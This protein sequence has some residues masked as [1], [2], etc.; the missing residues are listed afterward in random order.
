[1]IVVHPEFCPEEGRWCVGDGYE[2][3]SLRQLAAL[4]GPDYRI[5]GYWPDGLPLAEQRRLCERDELGSLSSEA[6]A[7]ML[8]LSPLLGYEP[9]RNPSV[10][11]CDG[12]VRERDPS[13][14]GQKP[15]YD[16][17]LILSLWALGLPTRVIAERVGMR[18]GK[19]V[20]VW[21]NHERSREHPDPRA[22]PRRQ[23]QVHRPSRGVS[24]SG[25]AA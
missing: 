22:L 6:K 20:S 4:L 18:D 13:T 7:T 24:I 14:P 10:R 16:R 12:S 1:M 15:K 23:R 2:A 19:I 25:A 17:E 5:D 21:M 9:T 3:R 8:R 11:T